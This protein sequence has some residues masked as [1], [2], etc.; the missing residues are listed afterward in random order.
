MPLVWSVSDPP[1]S[2]GCI[3]PM[4]PREGTGLGRSVERYSLFPRAIPHETTFR[5][6]PEGISDK[7]ADQERG[8]RGPDQRVSRG[9]ERVLRGYAR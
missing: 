3:P 7:T 4:I 2:V 9:P 5:G 6:Y 1:Y 8:S